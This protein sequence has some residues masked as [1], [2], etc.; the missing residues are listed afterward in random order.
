MA[1][2]P[3]PAEPAVDFGRCLEAARRESG[4]SYRK[5]A[6]KSGLNARRIEELETGV[7]LPTDREL[8][9]LAHGCG[10]SVFD[11]LPPGY[12]LRVLDHDEPAGA[13]EVRGREAIDA[14][15]REYISMVVELR[16]GREVTAPTLRHED[17]VELAAA[18]GD[19][20]ESIETKLVSLLD[21]D[22]VEIPAIRSMILPSTASDDRSSASVDA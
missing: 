16:S 5:L 14:L 12:T 21:A 9:A 6:R 1:S 19:T 18:L 11:L 4:L 17:L 22:A 7:E 15:L 20:P 2:I 10:L 3:E 13:Q 8:G